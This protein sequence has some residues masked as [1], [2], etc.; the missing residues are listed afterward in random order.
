MRDRERERNREKAEA[1]SSVAG[2]VGSCPACC[3]GWEVVRC[4]HT[5]GSDGGSNSKLK[6]AADEWRAAVSEQQHPEQQSGGKS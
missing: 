3:G 4:R 2:V 5:E 6:Q 1:G